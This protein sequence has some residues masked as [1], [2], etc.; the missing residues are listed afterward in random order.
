[1][2]VTNKNLVI[3]LDINLEQTTPLLPFKNNTKFLDNLLVNMRMLYNYDAQGNETLVIY[4]K[5]LQSKSLQG[6]L[7]F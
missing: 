6:T 2:Q 7:P 4:D 5:N 1:M 3:N